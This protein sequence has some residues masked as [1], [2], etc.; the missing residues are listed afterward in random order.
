MFFALNKDTNK[1]VTIEEAIEEKSKY[2]CP[3][4]K[5]DVLIRNGKIKISHFAHKTKCTES[6]TKDMTEWHKN[7]QDVFPK[8]NQEVVVECTISLRDFVRAS[9][10]YNF[11]YDIRTKDE[12]AL[13]KN[14]PETPIPL[15]HRADVLINDY[16]IE[17]QHSPISF[18]EFNERNWFYN[19][20]GYKVI[21]IFDMQDKNI[22]FLYC[23]DVQNFY[24]WLHPASTFLN[25]N[26]LDANVKLYFQLADPI[27]SDPDYEF[28]SDTTVEQVNGIYTYFKRF[29]TDRNITLTPLDL[30]NKVENNLL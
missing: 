27:T 28:E 26:V 2:V 10:K 15:K 14:N 16:V 23:S 29:Y 1:R 21:W 12:Y 4:C 25:F 9:G 3:I 30:K 19:Y 22:E 24:S 11:R 5:Q 7:W 17:F 6:F 13:T 18:E 20:C 8:E